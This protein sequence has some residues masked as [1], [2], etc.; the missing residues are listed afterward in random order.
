M[1]IRRK[2]R[3]LAG[4]AGAVL[5]LPLGVH[6]AMAGARPHHALP[7]LPDFVAEMADPGPIVLRGVYADGIFALPVIQQ[8]PS[9]DTFVTSSA[10]AVTQFTDA[11]EFGVTGL[12]A[13][14]YLS[15]A[16]FFELQSGQRIRLVY[17]DGRLVT[18]VVDRVLRF[19]ALQPTNPDT[20]FI[21][22]T[23]LAQLTAPQLFELVYTG[24][25]HVTFQTCIASNE[26]R[27]WGR[28]FVI[29]SP[30]RASQPERQGSPR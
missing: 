2:T 5:C 19:Q 3:I 14:N 27:S 20:D 6:P 30:L 18:Y 4:L 7:P 25:P 13:H 23:D 29:A 10:Q 26:S 1:N 12:L 16:L 8:P 24:S 28:L 17:S 9:D 21:N 22:L 11:S 15:G